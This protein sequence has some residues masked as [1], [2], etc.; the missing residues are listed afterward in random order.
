MEL[1]SRKKSRRDRMMQS[2]SFYTLEIRK[3]G[4]ERNRRVE[5]LSHLVNGNNRK[6][7][8]HGRKGMQRSGKIK[9]VKKKI[10][11]R[12]RKVL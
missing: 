12:T 5:R 6:C 10:H 7:L 2:K 11:A 3:I 4:S 8:P 1:D 9:S